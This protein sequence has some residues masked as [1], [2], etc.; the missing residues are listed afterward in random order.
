MLEVRLT[1]KIL[2]F[3]IC[4]SACVAG[5]H[6]YQISGEVLVLLY[7]HNLADS[8]ALP[9][10]GLEFAPLHVQSHH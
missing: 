5:F 1:V 8:E 7:H 3:D 6:Q 2:C 10:L 4:Q 9:V